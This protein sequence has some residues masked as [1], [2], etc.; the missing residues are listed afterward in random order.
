M[1]RVFVLIIALA[2]LFAGCG[3]SAHV[4]KPDRLSQMMSWMKE[5]VFLDVDQFRALTAAGRIPYKPMYHNYPEKLKE[6]LSE[7]YPC[8]QSKTYRDVLKDT[9][10]VTGSVSIE[11]SYIPVCKDDYKRAEQITRKKSDRYYVVGAM[12]ITLGVPITTTQA[13][14]TLITG[15]VYISAEEPGK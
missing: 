1:R 9:S 12:K 8:D 2:I 11:Y 14:M 7:P 15:T 13:L 10:V 4:Q 5:Y 3:Q 6:L